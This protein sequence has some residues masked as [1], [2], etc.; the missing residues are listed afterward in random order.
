MTDRQIKLTLLGTG[1]S[2]GVLASVAIGGLVTQTNPK[3]QTA[4]FGPY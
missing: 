4:M 2:G 1:S 3:P